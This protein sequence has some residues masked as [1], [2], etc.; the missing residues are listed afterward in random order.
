MIERNSKRI[1][2]ALNVKYFCCND[3]KSGIITNISEKDMYMKTKPCFPCNAIFEV[4]IPTG[5]EVLKVP[6]KIL[7]IDKKG[8]DNVGMGLKLLEQTEKYV[9]FL[10]TLKS[11]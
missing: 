3:L 11:P 6:V 2:T 7:R 1:N 9:K 4:L 5:N 8:N 10:N